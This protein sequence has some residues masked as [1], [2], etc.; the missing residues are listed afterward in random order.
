I[1][2][3]SDARVAL[4]LF[5]VPR[6]I[7]TAVARRSRRNSQH[8]ANSLTRPSCRRHLRGPS[9]PRAA[10]LR[11]PPDCAQDDRSFGAKLPFAKR[12]ILRV[13]G[14]GAHQSGHGLSRVSHLPLMTSP[15]KAICAPHFSAKSSHRGFFD[16]IKAIFFA[17][18]QPFNCFSRPIAL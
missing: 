14:A 10:P 17:L 9:T 1:V 13:E 8:G 5:T 4:R 11:E 7:S 12:S 2:R 6:I 16:S 15:A 18:A 3:M